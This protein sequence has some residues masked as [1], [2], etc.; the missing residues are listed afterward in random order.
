MPDRPKMITQTKR[1]TLVLQAGGLDVRMTTP[2]HKT[3]PLRNFNQS[4]G[5]VIKGRCRLWIRNLDL[6]LAMLEQY[7]DQDLQKIAQRKMDR[8][9]RQKC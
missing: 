4:L 1:D 8:C 3:H 6:E 9:S 2:P 7:S 5:T